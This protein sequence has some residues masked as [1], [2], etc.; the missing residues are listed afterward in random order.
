M[1]NNNIINTFIKS[2]I[3][4]LLVLSILILAVLSFSSCKT[5]KEPIYITKT[6]VDTIKQKELINTYDSVYISQYIKGDTIIVSKYKYKY[7]DKIKSDT[8]IKLDSIPYIQYQ[9]KIITKYPTEYK[10]LLIYTILSLLYI[11]YKFKSKI[12]IFNK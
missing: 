10:Y 4:I 11:I 9:D 8:I 3:T 2:Y 6:H 12:N 1:R 5:V 7:I